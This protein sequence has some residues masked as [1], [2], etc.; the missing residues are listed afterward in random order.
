VFNFTSNS[1]FTRS[2]AIAARSRTLLL[3]PTGT[4]LLLTPFV[5]SA[6][7]CLIASRSWPR[8]HD[9]PLMDYI[10]WR[11]TSGAVP[12]RDIFDMNLPGTYLIHLI[13]LR[14]F[15]RGD[16]GCRLFDFLWLVLT[17]V[18]LYGFC[19]PIS[20][21]GGMLAAL[22]FFAYHLSQ[23]AR[24]MGQRDFL[25]CL[26][27]IAG[28]HFLARSAEVGGSYRPSFL[29]GL[30]VGF[31]ASMKPHAAID[32]LFMLAVL[33]ACLRRKPRSQCVLNA[34]LFLAAAALVPAAIC[35]WL[36]VVGGLH[37]LIEIVTQYLLPYYPK[38]GGISSTHLVW[39]LL[40]PNWFWVFVSVV[41]W[42]RSQRGPRYAL[43]VLGAV[44]GVLHYA[45]QER[46]WWYH[47]YPFR[48]F[49]FILIAM[50][51]A[52]LF[53]RPEA[54]SRVCALLCLLLAEYP[55]SAA[56]YRASREPMS[57]ELA[58]N[59]KRVLDGL[60]AYLKPRLDPKI[61]TVQTMD[62]AGGAVDALFVLRVREA[63]RFMY[64]F[65][66]LYFGQ[67]PFVRQL[68]L[69]F[70]TQIRASAPKYVVLFRWSW[71]PPSDYGRLDAFPEFRQWLELHYVKEFER[72]DYQI[73]RRGERSICPADASL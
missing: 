55:L 42:E 27:L 67:E 24:S 14:V 37:P 7:I 63:T 29:A 48:A 26:S 10:A 4:L 66:L 12:Y 68:R 41:P 28:A 57:S 20:R 49:F 61:D 30:L 17:T 6:V 36:A 44:Y 16:L 18:A 58:F 3:H 51:L 56:C 53:S 38:L 21:W 2:P 69:Q 64:D 11:I 34:L 13:E 22:F 71:P 8:I 40:K 50:S 35:V 15:G 43:T 73:F 72:P 62:T 59:Q 25:L 65:H 23:G 46:G 31:G 5:G 19:R 32:G 47:E 45:L 52:G 70:M 33:V 54:K 9:G 39:G 1:T 60:V